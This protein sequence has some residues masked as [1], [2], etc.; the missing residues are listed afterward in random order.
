MSDT[1]AAF[2]AALPEPLVWDSSETE[3]TRPTAFTLD[4]M[5]AIF[6]AAWNARGEEDARWLDAE[7]DRQEK[8]WNEHLASGKGG[9][10]TTFHTIPRAYATAIR[11]MK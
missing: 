3:Y 7:A 2:E 10:A 8:A 1:A 9:P 4:Q 11:G 6:D 5:R